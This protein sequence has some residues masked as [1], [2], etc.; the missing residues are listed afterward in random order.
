MKFAL[1]F[2]EIPSKGRVRYKFLCFTLLYNL[3]IGKIR[4]ATKSLEFSAHNKCSIYWYELHK[5]T[6]TE[7]INM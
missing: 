6:H 7:Y 2:L 5:Y 4:K 3:F 1:L